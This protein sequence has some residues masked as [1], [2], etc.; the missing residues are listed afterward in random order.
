MNL[1]RG[2]GAQRGE[3]RQRAARLGARGPDRGTSSWQPRAKVACKLKAATGALV[4]DRASRG[5][6]HHGRRQLIEILAALIVEPV[7]VGAQ[8]GAD[9]PRDAR[10]AVAER[11]LSKHRGDLNHAGAKARRAMAAG[12][13]PH[14]LVAR[15]L[16]A[17]L[18]K[19]STHPG[20]GHGHLAQRGDRTTRSRPRRPARDREAKPSHALIFAHADREP[21]SAEPLV[22]YRTRRAMRLAQTAAV[23][24]LMASAFTQSEDPEVKRA[25]RASRSQV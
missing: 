25:A 3:R 24:P 22:S 10:R 6:P 14:G 15:L 12:H 20:L 23:R 5:G 4:L 8:Q 1:L 19:R 21:D 17:R 2:A 13:Q 18:Q 16:Q 11:L 9:H 7:V